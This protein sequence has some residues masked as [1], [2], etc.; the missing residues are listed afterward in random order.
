LMR[1]RLSNGW[2]GQGDFLLHV[3]LRFSLCLWSDG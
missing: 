3:L 2:V 1:A